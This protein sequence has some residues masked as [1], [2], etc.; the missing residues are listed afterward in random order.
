MGRTRPRLP[1]DEIP[2][3]R[4]TLTRILALAPGEMILV[5]G[6]ALA[7]WMIR[8]GL[9]PKPGRAA[10]LPAAVSSDADFLGSI[11]HALAL[12]HGLGARLIEPDK[13]AMTALVGQ[14]RIKAASGLEYN[15]DVLH[16][17]F[18]SGGLRKSIEFTRRV[19]KRAAQVQMEGGKTVRILHPVDVL[20]SRI[21]NAAGLLDVKGPHVLTQTRWAVRVARHALEQLVQ[22]REQH[23]DRPGALASELFRLACSP[24]G[25]LVWA[26]HQ[27]EI[28]AAIPFAMLIDRLP[29]FAKQSDA[30]IDALRR[31]GRSVRV[32]GLVRRGAARER[33]GRAFKG[34][35]RIN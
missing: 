3:D 35:A 19:R 14:I 4:E 1:V 15:V 31:D 10:P 33:A 5:G 22:S 23:A 12:T 25:R 26:R 13:N 29:G 17:I 24:A 2:I 7:F 11:E 8:F 6:Q 27:I 18:D 21:Q 28:A 34:G 16:Q 32:G 9:G 20:A 30:M